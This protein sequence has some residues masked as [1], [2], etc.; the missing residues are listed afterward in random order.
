MG[1]LQYE[2]RTHH[3]LLG[4]RKS[5]SVFDIEPCIPGPSIFTFFRAFLGHFRDLKFCPN[6][7]KFP[8]ISGF[9]R[10]SGH[11]DFRA[12]FGRFSG[13]SGVGQISCLFR[14]CGD[15]GFR[16]FRAIF[17]KPANLAPADTSKS[18]FSALRRPRNH[19]FGP[20]DTSKSSF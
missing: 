11:L 15:L 13:N 9:F 8:Q 20:A 5:Y 4:P 2:V 1:I 12:I 6:F 18:S 7:P 19:R 10:P 3:P 17:G 14:P 16:D